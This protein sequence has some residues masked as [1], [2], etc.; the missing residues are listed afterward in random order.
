VKQQILVA[1]EEAPIRQM[2]AFNLMHAGS[3]KRKFLCDKKF[4]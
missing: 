4:W 1:E 3:G 2:I